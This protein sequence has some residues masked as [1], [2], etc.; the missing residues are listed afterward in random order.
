VELDLSKGLERKIVVGDGNSISVFFFK[1]P[2]RIADFEIVAE[3]GFSE[4]LR[5]G[6]NLLGRKG[7]FD[8]FQVC[9]NDRE[10]VLSFTPIE[11]A[12]T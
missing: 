12:F 9:F 1:V 4:Q 3:R 2:V 8:R 10:R 6:F 7:I 11:A 5:I